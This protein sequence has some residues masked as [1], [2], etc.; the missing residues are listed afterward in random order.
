M[1]RLPGFILQSPN[2][3]WQSPRR[4]SLQ[5]PYSLPGGFNALGVGVKW[6]LGISFNGGFGVMK[7]DLV[8]IVEHCGDYLVRVDKPLPQSGGLQQGLGVVNRLFVLVT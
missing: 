5:V 8:V 7:N 6:V 3:I 1:P 4:R 2:R